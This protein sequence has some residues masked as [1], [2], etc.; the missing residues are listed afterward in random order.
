MN[1]P[2]RYFDDINMNITNRGTLTMIHTADIHFG[3]MDPF[4]EYK[5]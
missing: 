2:I 1:F 4:T 5:I 3:C